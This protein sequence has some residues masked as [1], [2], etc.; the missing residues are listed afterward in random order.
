[1]STL[2]S[3]HRP[4]PVC[5]TTA[6]RF[7]HHQRFALPP[8]HPLPPAFNIVA[9]PACDF[10]YADTT[11]DAA[12]YDR[13]YTDYSKYADQGTSTGG[14]GDP[15]DQSRIEE[16]AREIGRHLPD[17]AA[18]VV[19]IG[20]ANGGM[21][22]ALRALGY[23]NLLGID[24]SPDCVA[25]TKRLFG[26]PAQQGWLGALPAEVA[27]A[28]LVIL[29]HVLEHVLD[30]AEAVR[31]VREVLA[32]AGLVYVEVPD[33]ARYAECLVAPFQD[34]NSE[35]INHFSQASLANLF[36]AHGFE[37]VAE[38]QKTVPVAGGFG[39]PACFSFFRLGA[40]S[41]RSGE[42]RRAPDFL[43][44]IDRYI[45]HSASLLAAVD[46]RL[47]LVPPG[48]VIVWGVGQL[49]LKL[50]V[51]TRLGRAEIAAFTDG[52]PLHHGK[53][54]HGRPIV[55]PERL[56]DLPP[57]P[58]IVGTMLHQVAIA[59]RIQRDLALDNP[60]VTLA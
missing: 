21:L 57:Y 47:A 36:A 30:L 25:N 46:A 26:I 48:P 60:V 40:E 24:P 39:Y 20:C 19:D 51:E 41:G 52:N 1:M 42:W 17:R 49:T 28:G 7:L 53:Q 10:V 32:P 59:N 12:A 58:I 9:C 8:G 27:P 54:L 33:A 6:A 38:G 50:L 4:C 16:M 13:Y 34:F 23:E 31:R 29:S 18:R 5:G 44:E 43:R 11:A 22:A 14:G 55:A 56:R 15:R 3:V 45:T 37:L 2:Q 35:H